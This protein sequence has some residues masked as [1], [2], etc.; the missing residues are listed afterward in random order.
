ML[1]RLS[2]RPHQDTLENKARIQS[3]FIYEI[4]LELISRNSKTKDKNKTLTTAT[5]K[6]AVGKL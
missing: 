2:H 5:K 4:L 6:Q 3:R 1:G